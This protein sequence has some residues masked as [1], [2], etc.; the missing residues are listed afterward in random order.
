ME[1]NFRTPEGN[2]TKARWVDKS[3]FITFA[4]V[5]ADLAYWAPFPGQSSTFDNLRKRGAKYIREEKGLQL[6]RA[7]KLRRDRNDRVENTLVA[8]K[9]GK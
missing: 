9:A 4:E 1:K 6:E 2:L 7:M 8:S 3:T 5:P